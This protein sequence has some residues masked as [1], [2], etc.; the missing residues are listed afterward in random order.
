MARSVGGGSPLSDADFGSS[1]LAKAPGRKHARK[2]ILTEEIVTPVLPEPGRRRLSEAERRTIRERR[3]PGELPPLDPSPVK[4]IDSGNRRKTG[5]RAMLLGGF[6]FLGMAVVAFGG[7]GLFG[8]TPEPGVTATAAPGPTATSIT[9]V[10]APVL[11]A[12]PLVDATLAPMPTEIAV[13]PMDD[14]NIVCLD[15][16]HG[17]WDPGWTR[18]ATDLAP[19]MTEA[20]ITLGQAWDLAA[21]LRERGITVVMT[22]ESGIPANPF[23][24]DVNGDG[25][26]LR[27]SERDGDFD[28]LQTRINICNEAEADVL[29]SLHVN[30]HTDTEA[31]GYETWYTAAPTRPFGDQSFRFATLLYRA[32][33]EGFASVG[34]ESKG[35][36]VKDDIGADVQVA[37]ASE[38]HFIITGPALNRP[39]GGITPSQMPGAIVEAVFI[40]NDTDAVFLASTEGQETIVSAYEAA[41][42]QYFVEYPG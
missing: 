9:T 27:D 17:G 3:K 29:V 16:G 31:R 14:R 36:G 1:P 26:T 8:A 15:P 34:F 35:R 20:E 28:E 18:D 25:K 12:T 11:A 38:K 21:R 24:L 41:I 37:H 30:G 6:L 23:D 19:Q 33:E 10:G 7:S 2:R 22:R 4:E 5:G 42:V 13:D 39:I 40:S 32:L